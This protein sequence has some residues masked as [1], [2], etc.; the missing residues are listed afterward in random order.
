M[1]LNTPT[2]LILLNMRKIT[3]LLF[4]LHFC[5]V[6]KVNA[7]CTTSNATGCSCLAPGST[8]CDLLPDIIVGRPP[9]LV[10]G[11]NGVIEYSQVGN[12][13]ENGRLRVSVTSPNIGRGPL[14]V[15]TTNKYICGTD[16]IVGTAPATCPNTGLPPRQLV[17]QRVYHKT[18]NAM[19]YYDRDAGSMTYHPTHGHMHVDDW[20][21]YTLR[22]ATTDPNPLNWPI[23]GTGA[24]LAFCLMD[25]G[26]CSTYNGH[27]VD[28]NGN[29]LLNGNFPNYG[30]GGGSYNCSASVQ[31]ISSG[32]T[33]IYYQYLDGMYLNI[34]PGTCNGN[35]FIVVNIDPNNYFLEENENNNVI[36]VPYTL[37][38]QAGTVPTITPSG[39]TAICPGSSVVL[40]SNP[41][42]SYLWSN[43][44]T[45]QSITVTTPGTYTVTTNVNTTCPATSLPV[46]VT[47]QS[48]PVTVT[49]V[50]GNICPG[51]STT[52]NSSVTTPSTGT[53]QTSFSNNTVYNIPD[54]NATGVS[55]PITVS[56]IS[57][58]TLSNGSIFSVQVNITHT[59]DGDL[60]LTLISPSGNSIL[61]S[62][63]RG[64]SGDNF[65]NT[66]FSMTAATTIASGT[67]P[68]NGSYIP[69]AS[70]NSLT[71]NANGTWQ[72]KVSDHAGT[73][74]GTINSWTLKL[75]NVVPVQLTYS[76]S[77]NPAGF[78]ST[79]ANPVVTPAVSTT[80]TV[81][82]TT[83]IS[84]CIGTTSA[85]VNVNPVVLTV[86][87]NVQICSGGTTVL[88]AGGATSYLWSPATGLSATTGS[89]V[90]ANPLATTTYTV[91]GTNSTGCTSQQSVTVT[92]NSLPV[93]SVGPFT[94]VCSNAAAFALSS[95]SPTGGVYSG[96]GVSNG[97]FNP[98]TAGVGT[99]TIT[100]TYTNGNGCTSFATANITVN[101]LPVVT[102]AA[103]GSLC[104]NAAAI[105]LSGG[106]PS[107]GVYSGTGVS[108]GMFNPATAGVGTHTITYTYT[109]SNGCTSFAT[110]TITVNDCGCTVPKVPGTMT[111]LAKIC[112]NTPTVYSVV[113]VATVTSYNWTPPAGVTIVSGQGTNS[114]TVVSD[115]NFLSG[116]L[117]VT[118]NNACGSS[119]ARCKTI[120]KFTATTP[121]SIVGE[122]Y[123]HCGSVVNLSVAAIA[124]AVS[125]DWTLPAGVTNI[126][127]QGTN[128]IS[129]S[130]PSGF[131]S[132]QVCV[133]SNNGCMNSASRCA[134][135]YGAPVRPVIGGA[136]FAC[137]G[138]TK[139]YFVNPSYGATTYT[140]TVPTG[141]TIV[142]G[143][144]TPSIEV[145][146][147]S[148]AGYVRCTAINACGNRGAASLNITITCRQLNNV[149][150]DFNVLVNPNP[151]SESA[152]I[153]LPGA[154][155]SK[156]TVTISN[157]IGKDIFSESFAYKKDET[158][159][160]DLS[161][162]AK[163]LYL[164]T[165]SNSEFRKI[166]RLIIE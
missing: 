101:S 58:S 45:T 9:L 16:T 158:I 166:T 144:G 13:V 102:L 92:V 78:S 113:N 157:V 143:Q 3:L 12:G 146:F 109:N 100:Y 160:L 97:I 134:T 135:I 115:A 21:V 29:T 104:N 8:D 112:P 75:N 88:N 83:N 82:V 124:N 60:K 41:E 66:I 35:Y 57:P 47:S 20:G 127:G 131:T 62:N 138:E 120:S 119:T 99:H 89:S 22:S 136:N 122:K 42:P 139:T 72:L 150:N 7:Q 32:Y 36:V 110:A 55:S 95:G 31:G 70:F 53:V 71:G 130:T 37:T 39:S 96:P 126:S 151:A 123:G 17:V 26:S 40:T 77:S 27:C 111:G 11:N 64:G 141:S 165:V 85:T 24:K 140:W 149:N 43:G 87:P 128:A 68:F 98:A 129:F 152:I 107:G 69:D 74:I 137:P 51:Q 54:N 61:L 34:P 103:F 6:V 2:S 86:S 44:A 163:G 52:L 90:N 105:T 159:P 164:V 28:A 1:I 145:T 25:Y 23:I 155:D 79:S 33:D 59:Y 73:D 142:S 10:S 94:A 156:I 81:N 116:S 147:G 38:K 65:N 106:S 162:Y 49:P 91:T 125:Y 121:G 84:S 14:E 148:T 153:S 161:K 63:Q 46:T 50:A 48:L 15:R 4:V 114:V 133:T 30:L 118:A 80:Y 5:L 76:W 108:N 18:G 19:S 67:A 132:G 117:C 56:G 93:V 154:D